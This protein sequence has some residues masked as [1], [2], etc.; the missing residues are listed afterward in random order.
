MKHGVTGKR[1]YCRSY[2]Y[3]VLKRQPEAIAPS[4]NFTEKDFEL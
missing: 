4:G 1:D 2:K 3:D